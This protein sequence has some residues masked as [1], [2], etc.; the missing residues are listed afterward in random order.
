MNSCHSKLNP[1]TK[2]ICDLVR[3]CIIH[4]HDGTVM[5][6][7]CTLDCLYVGT[8]KWLDFDHFMKKNA[9]ID[10]RCTLSALEHKEV[11]N[12][13]RDKGRRF[14]CVTA[15]E[16][17]VIDYLLSVSTKAVKLK[18][19]YPGYYKGCINT[20]P[21]RRRSTISLLLPT[22]VLSLGA[23]SAHAFASQA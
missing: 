6:H 12:T 5:D 19:C 20:A 11:I 22:Q 14:V 1:V 2:Q 9:G 21:Y 17:G 23:L 13:L 3:P 18:D 10:V 4:V 16:S 8:E 15:Y 7:S